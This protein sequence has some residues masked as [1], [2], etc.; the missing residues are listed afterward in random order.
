LP[1]HI[2]EISKAILSNFYDILSFEQHMYFVNIILTIY[3]LSYNDFLWFCISR[4]I[5]V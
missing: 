2:S 3:Q 5:I 1:A 4:I